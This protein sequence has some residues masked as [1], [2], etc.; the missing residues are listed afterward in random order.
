MRSQAELGLKKFQAD[1]SANGLVSRVSQFTVDSFQPSFPVDGVGTED[2]CTEGTGFL[3]R[4]FKG[5]GQLMKDIHP[6]V[7][8]CRCP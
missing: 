6:F 3:K 2:A 5:L 1:P 7:I 8:C 4:L